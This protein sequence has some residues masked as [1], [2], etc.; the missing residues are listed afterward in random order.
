[1]GEKY[2]E[3]ASFEKTDFR[4]PGVLADEYD[5]CHFINCNFAETVLSHRRFLDCTFAGCNLSLAKLNDT[6]FSNTVFDQC[7][8][9]GLHFEDCYQTVFS[10][11]FTDCQLNLS[12]F[13]KLNLKNSTF[14][15]CTLHEVDFSEADLTAVVLDDC[16]LYRAVFDNTVL[17]KADL[18]TAYNYSINPEKNR[19]RKAKFSL[20]NI[21]GLLEQYDIIVE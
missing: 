15:K 17:A 16:D 21:R 3:D 8:L 12:S 4:E 20:E 7:K 1:M 6:A 2:I 9:L 5:H 14:S 19:I 13:Y 11:T 18:R 10:T